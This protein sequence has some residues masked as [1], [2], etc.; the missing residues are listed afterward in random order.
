MLVFVLV[1][2]SA[3]RAH[4]LSNPHCEATEGEL[5]LLLLLLVGDDDKLLFL[6]FDGD[7][8]TDFLLP[9]RRLLRVDAA[10]IKNDES[11]IGK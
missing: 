2:S 3:M 7:D 8:S 4:F 1:G 6:R 10:T 9:L 5:L 11:S